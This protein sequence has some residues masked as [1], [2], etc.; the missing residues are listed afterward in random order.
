[1]YCSGSAQA[2]QQ[3][4]RPARATDAYRRGES[5]PEGASDLGQVEGEADERGCRPSRDRRSGHG[6]SDGC[7]P[8]ASGGQRGAHAASTTP[9][10]A[11]ASCTASTRPRPATEKLGSLQRLPVPAA[12]LPRGPRAPLYPDGETGR[13]GSRQEC[14]SSKRSASDAPPRSRQR[15]PSASRRGHRV[16]LARRARRRLAARPRSARSTADREDPER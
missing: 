10:I 15:P 4:G 1:M 7:A 9:V 16:G 14:G 2:L 3:M 8:A 11:T 6:E 12:T 5:L 13:L